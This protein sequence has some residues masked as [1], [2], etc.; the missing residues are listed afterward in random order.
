MR[1]NRVAAVIA[2]DANTPGLSQIF[3]LEEGAMADQ[4]VDVTK[5][6]G[7]IITLILVVAYIVDSAHTIHAAHRVTDF[8]SLPNIRGE[9]LVLLGISHAGYLGGKIAPTSNGN[10]AGG[11]IAALRAARPANQA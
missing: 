9:F 3:M 7:F 2:R 5:F 11:T 10:P 8:T 4:A 6:Q 1:A